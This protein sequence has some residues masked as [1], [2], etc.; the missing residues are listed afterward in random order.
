MTVIIRDREHQVI[1]QGRN[2]RCIHDRSRRVA[3]AKVRIVGVAGGGAI[4]RVDWT[5][6][7]YCRVGWQS[8]GLACVWARRARFSAATVTM[9]PYTGQPAGMP[10]VPTLGE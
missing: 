2:L 3:P 10:L 4:A 9:L 7:S 1:A 6:G 8:Y 5:D